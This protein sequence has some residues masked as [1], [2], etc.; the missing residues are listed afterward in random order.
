[1][2]APPFSPLGAAVLSRFGLWWEIETPV[3]R[4][5]LP[6][7][8][9]MLQKMEGAQLQVDWTAGSL[10]HLKAPKIPARLLTLSAMHFARELARCGGQVEALVWLTWDGRGWDLIT[11]P[12]EQSRWRVE[13][14]A[15][16]PDDHVALV[17]HSHGRA[18][19]FFSATDHASEQDGFLYGVLG[20]LDPARIQNISFKFR[21]GHAGCFLPLHIGEIFDVGP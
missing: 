21:A 12:Q 16:Q 5:R 7:P 2:S 11:P 20:G 14:R 1:M 19:A 9:R 6:L 4:A 13:S 10:F 17:L 15:I 8:W 3:Y 18:P